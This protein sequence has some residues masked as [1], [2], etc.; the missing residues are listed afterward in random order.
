MEEPSVKQKLKAS[1]A[2]HFRPLASPSQ[3]AVRGLVPE[4]V[5]GIEIPTDRNI[6]RLHVGDP[7]FATPQHIVEA[8]LEAMTE[9]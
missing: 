9:G 6:A 5:T 8:A 3:A 1:G 4:R 2:D 7:C